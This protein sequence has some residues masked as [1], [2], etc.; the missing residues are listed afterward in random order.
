ML[1]KHDLGGLM[2]D[3]VNVHL[4][5]RGIKIATGTIVDATMR[6]SS[7]RLPRPR[8][9]PVSAIRRCTRPRR[10]TSG[11]SGCH[12]RLRTDSNHL[13]DT[14][15]KSCIGGP[16][17]QSVGN[18]SLALVDRVSI[19]TP[20]MRRDDGCRTAF[21]VDR[22]CVELVIPCQV[23]ADRQVVWSAGLSGQERIE[24]NAERSCICADEQ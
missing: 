2:L 21:S 19:Q 14:Q 15:I 3:A 11:T 5:A 6:P 24:A 7:T 4:E 18:D 16:C 8:T 9:R 1:E 12:D 10:A 23:A 13:T 20:V 17:S 22:A